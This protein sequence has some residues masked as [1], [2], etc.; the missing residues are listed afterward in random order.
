MGDYRSLFR[1][2]LS[3]KEYYNFLYQSFVDET[4]E[5]STSYFTDVQEEVEFGSLLWEN[6]DIRITSLIDVKTGQRISDDYKKLL[7]KDLTYKPS[8]GTRYQFDDNIWMVFSTDNIKT[9]ISSVYVRRCNEVLTTLDKYGNIH[10]EPC[11]VDY[12]VIETSL[13]VGDTLNAPRAKVRTFCQ[14]NY[15]TSGIKISDRYIWGKQAYRISE[16]D[17]Y[18]RTKTFDRD[19]VKILSFLSNYD[20]DDSADDMETGLANNAQNIN[21]TISIIGGDINQIVNFEGDMQAVVRLNNT[22]VNEAVNWYSLNPTI[23]TITK[24]GHLITNVVGSTKLVAKL[25]GNETITSDIDIT[26]SQALIVE[27]NDIITPNVTYLRL[28]TEQ[29]YSIYEYANGIRQNSVFTI[30]STGVPK[31]PKNSYVLSV[32]DGNTFT[33]KN[34]ESTDIGVLKVICQ[35][36][37]NQKITNIFIELG[38][39]F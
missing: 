14:L 29:Q 20:N 24:T 5:E 32:I 31:L 18:N 16:W 8:L 39:A 13:E 12:N 38:G 17:K 36:N 2:Q 19:S 21:Y 1:K 26:I 23:A 25:K 7:F 35:N 30:T 33:V 9:P 27:N 3:T 11:I 28:R 37:T 34:L 6:I 22:I 10:Y 4:F 15:Y